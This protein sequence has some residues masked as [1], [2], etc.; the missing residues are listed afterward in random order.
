MNMNFN[1]RP[2]TSTTF[3]RAQVQEFCLFHVW[4]VFNFTGKNENENE[5]C[6]QKRKKKLFH[7]IITFFF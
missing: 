3:K 2:F 5:N 6:E 4:H 7:S 1:P